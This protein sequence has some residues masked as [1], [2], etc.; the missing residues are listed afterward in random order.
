VDIFLEDCCVK[1]DTILN[2]ISCYSDH[3]SMPRDIWKITDWWKTFKVRFC[4]FPKVK[5]LKVSQGGLGHKLSGGGYADSHV[6]GLTR[7]YKFVM[8]G[9]KSG[10]VVVKWSFTL[11]ILGLNSDIWVSLKSPHLLKRIFRWHKPIWTYI[12]IVFFFLLK[13]IKSYHLIGFSFR[14]NNLQ[15][16]PLTLFKEELLPP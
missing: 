7:I 2:S 1:F 11:M 15:F 9:F 10:G 12:S 4:F 16:D 6:E 14:S 13:P 3:R 8:N 5:C